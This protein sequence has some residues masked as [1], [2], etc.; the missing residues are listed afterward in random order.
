MIWERS[1][2]SRCHFRPYSAASFPE[3]LRVRRSRDRESIS[4]SL[5][6]LRGRKGCNEFQIRKNATQTHS[7][8]K[9]PESALH[10]DESGNLLKK[11]QSSENRGVFDEVKVKSA[12]MLNELSRL[13]CSAFKE[14]GRLLNSRFY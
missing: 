7:T 2:W 8:L 9:R 5:S 13:E 4:V 6:V 12:R 10:S 3:A 11:E 14:K 1:T